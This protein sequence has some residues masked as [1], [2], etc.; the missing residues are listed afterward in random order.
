MARVVVPVL[1]F[2]E[3]EACRKWDHLR[4]DFRESPEADSLRSR[5]LARLTE[6]VGIE[7]NRD[8]AKDVV[9]PDGEYFRL[10]IYWISLQRVL[11]C[12][13]VKG[14]FHRG[15]P[16]NLYRPLAVLIVDSTFIPLYQDASNVYVAPM[17]IKLARN[18][19][20]RSLSRRGYPR[21]G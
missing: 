19:T 14:A 6:R 8:Q 16:V 12:G 7:V 11:C 15:A 17:R 9:H 21:G 3:T 20:L 13:P 5:F 4:P 2:Q 18:Y 1:L 10:G